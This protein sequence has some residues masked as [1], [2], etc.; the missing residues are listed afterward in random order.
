MKIS[1]YPYRILIQSWDEK[2]IYVMDMTADIPRKVR[3][4]IMIDDREFPQIILHTASFDRNFTEQ[5]ELIF[6]AFKRTGWVSCYID[7]EFEEHEQFV[8]TYYSDGIAFTPG[9]LTEV[10]RYVRTHAYQL[11]ALEEVE[12]NRH[13]R[14]MKISVVVGVTVVIGPSEGRFNGLNDYI[15][16]YIVEE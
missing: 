16:F 8:A 2:Y 5:E 12:K 15:D 3:N 9:R 10:G 13:F 7:L 1:T 6:F 4:L 14:M 11:G